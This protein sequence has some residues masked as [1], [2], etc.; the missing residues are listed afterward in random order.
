M[1]IKWDINNNMSKNKGNGIKQMF[2]QKIYLV[3]IPA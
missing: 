2:T 1:K 3:T